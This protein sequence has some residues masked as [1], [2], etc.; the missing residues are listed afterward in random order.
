MSQSILAFLDLAAQ[1]DGSLK[2]PLQGLLV[3]VFHTC[4]LFSMLKLEIVKM[5][6]QVQGTR[7]DDFKGSMATQKLLI[8]TQELGRMQAMKSK[9]CRSQ[10]RHAPYLLYIYP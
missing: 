9:A 8:T 1:V 2:L 6:L 3:L 4:R 10:T 7:Q 5:N